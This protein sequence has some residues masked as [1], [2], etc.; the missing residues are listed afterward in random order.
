[1]EKEASMTRLETKKI[2][3]TLYFTNEK[4]CPIYRQAMTLGGF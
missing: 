1:M 3:S 2:I 4:A